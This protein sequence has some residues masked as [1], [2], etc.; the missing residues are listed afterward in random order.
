MASS[1]A[2]TRRLAVLRSHLVGRIDDGDASIF[3]SSSTSSSPDAPTSSYPPL[4]VLSAAEAVAD[5][6]DGDVITVIEGFQGRVLAG[7][8]GERARREEEEARR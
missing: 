5:I 2:S 7:G 4:R 6:K 3:A 8:G 1:A